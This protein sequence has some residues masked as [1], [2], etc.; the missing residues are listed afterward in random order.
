MFTHF[1]STP[2]HLGSTPP[3]PLNFDNGAFNSD[4]EVFYFG[5]GANNTERE[6][7]YSGVG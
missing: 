1:L 7:F 5:G 2:L 6:A 4:I 3:P